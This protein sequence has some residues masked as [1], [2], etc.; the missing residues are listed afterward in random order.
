MGLRAKLSVVF[1]SLLVAAVLLV[2][3]VEIDR[4]VRLMVDG[5]DA[6][7]TTLINQTFNQIGMCCKFSG[8]GW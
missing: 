2:S 1:L 8:V 6:S 5:L 7:A 4:T 3:A